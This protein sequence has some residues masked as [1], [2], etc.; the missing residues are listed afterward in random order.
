MLSLLSE[1]ILSE[2]GTWLN[3]DSRLPSGFIEWSRSSVRGRRRPCQAML[4]R[5]RPANDIFTASS[6]TDFAY[7]YTASRIVLSHCDSGGRDLL[8][9]ERK[10]R[11][12]VNVFTQRSSV[13]HVKSCFGSFVSGTEFPIKRQVG[14]T[15]L[16]IS[17]PACCLL[18]LPMH[19]NQSPDTQAETSLSLCWCVSVGGLSLFCFASSLT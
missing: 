5:W 17:T 10:G 3:L 15:A 14:R 2:A 13:Y 16:I 11:V 8:C 12:R 6:S 18:P 4:A 1:F 9:Y 19:Q 7:A